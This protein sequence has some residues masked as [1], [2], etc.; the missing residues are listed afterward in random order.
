MY[1][2]KEKDILKCAKFWG[3]YDKNIV[4]ETKIA[5]KDVQKSYWRIKY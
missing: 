2:C 3:K 1:R 5:W 4:S